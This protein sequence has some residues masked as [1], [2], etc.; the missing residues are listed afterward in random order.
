[1]TKETSHL[2][3]IYLNN[4]GAVQTS[5]EAPSIETLNLNVEGDKNKNKIK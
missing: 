3:P 2:I 4:F 5:S 1:M